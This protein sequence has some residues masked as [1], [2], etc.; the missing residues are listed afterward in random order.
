[1]MLGKLRKDFQLRYS[2]SFFYKEGWGCI[3]QFLFLYPL[4][5]AN[6]T[7]KIKIRT[8]G[9]GRNSGGNF[10]QVSET[11][12]RNSHPKPCASLSVAHFSPLPQ[13]QFFALPR[14]KRILGKMSRD[15]NCSLESFLQFD[16]FETQPRPN[17]QP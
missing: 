1:M 7:I 14:K 3:S 4:V 12:P 6:I 2:L 8:L 17:P 9:G 5:Q 15:Q 11:I 10:S 16:I 13:N